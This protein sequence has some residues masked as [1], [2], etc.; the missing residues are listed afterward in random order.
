MDNDQ[1]PQSSVVER[2]LAIGTDDSITLAA[3]YVHNRARHSNTAIEKQLLERVVRSLCDV[4][5]ATKVDECGINIRLLLHQ[6][7]YPGELSIWR[8]AELLD[9]SRLR[10][11]ELQTAGTRL[12]EIVTASGKG[13][14]A[15]L[16]KELGTIVERRAA[17]PIEIAL[18]ALEAILRLDEL[19]DTPLYDADWQK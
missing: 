11:W 2:A 10:S 5:G 9:A 7:F 6:A 17:Y 4:I 3:F 14:A 16:R 8:N 13:N 18:A 1:D 19:T 15:Q 12:K